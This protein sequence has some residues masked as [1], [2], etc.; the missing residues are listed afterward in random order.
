MLVDTAALGRALGRAVARVEAEQA[1]M[2]DLVRIRALIFEDGGRFPVPKGNRLR[3]A[4]EIAE[5]R[6]LLAGW[7]KDLAQRVRARIGPGDPLARLAEIETLLDAIA[8]D[9]DA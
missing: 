6:A 2:A 5:I 3:A 1:P 4:G 9:P 7:P 8:L